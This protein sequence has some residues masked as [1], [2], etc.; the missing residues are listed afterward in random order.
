MAKATYTPPPKQ[1]GTVTLEMPLNVAV[2]IRA[3][4]GACNGNDHQRSAVYNAL[5][6]VVCQA[7]DTNDAPRLLRRDTF[8]QGV[9]DMMH[10]FYVDTL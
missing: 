5:D 2:T 4:L 8:R 10:T 9:I 3:L 7:L 6:S 1:E